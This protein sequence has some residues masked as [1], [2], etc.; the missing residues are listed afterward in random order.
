MLF[1]GRLSSVIGLDWNNTPI[2]DLVDNGVFGHFF[3]LVQSHFRNV[4]LVS[5]GWE[6]DLLAIAAVR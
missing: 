1:L 4:R 2:G 5:Q 3:C 6:N